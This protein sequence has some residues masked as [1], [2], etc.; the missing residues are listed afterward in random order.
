MNNIHANTCPYKINKPYPPVCV[1]RPNLAYASEMLSNMGGSVS[2]MNDVSLYFYNAVITDSKYSSIAK[3]FHNISIVEMHHLN[4]FAEL[5]LQLGED[6][7]LWSGEVHKR[8]WTPAFNIYPREIR[9]L[10]A[11]SIEHEK[12]AIRKYSEQASNIEDKNIVA[13]LNRIILDEEH[14]IQIFNEM[15]Q[16]I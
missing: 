7:R 3:C 8:W 12:S 13:I 5:A 15:Y 2:E 1:E 10:I 14:H 9:A 6:P 11:N 16:H 4:I